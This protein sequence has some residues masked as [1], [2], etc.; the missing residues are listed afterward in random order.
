MCHFCLR[1]SCSSSPGLKSGF[2]VT[3]A[4]ASSL[5]VLVGAL[6]IDVEAEDGGAEVCLGVDDEVGIDSGVVGAARGA[7][8]IASA[9]A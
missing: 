6:L 1:L 8:S 7:G 5:G 4:A 3:L 2:G 9:R